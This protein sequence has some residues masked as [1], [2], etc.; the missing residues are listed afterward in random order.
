MSQLLFKPLES[1]PDA[2]NQYLFEIGLDPEFGKI[3]NKIFF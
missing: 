1:T 3:K 2:I